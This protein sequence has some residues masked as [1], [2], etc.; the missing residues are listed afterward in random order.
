MSHSVAV[1]KASIASRPLIN[2]VVVT[3]LC[4]AAALVLGLLAYAGWW[5]HAYRQ[6]AGPRATIDLRSS[7]SEKPY[8]LTFCAGLASNFHGFPGHAYVNWN[9]KPG[10][11]TS[12]KN[13]IG[14]ITRKYNDQFL[15]PFVAVP[16]SLHY[17]AQNY[18]QRNLDCLTAVVDVKTFN[19]TRAACATWDTSNFKAGTHDCVAFTTY[20]A[21]TAG[22]V[23]PEGSSRYPQDHIKLLKTL[24]ENLNCHHDKARETY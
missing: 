7:T 3:V 22:L 15:A 6:P 18:N 5:A 14:Y 20:I 16:G 11:T 21:R 23:V 2:R 1:T 13:S 24:N 4:L 19:R 10:V 12:A 17:D 9:D 8:Y